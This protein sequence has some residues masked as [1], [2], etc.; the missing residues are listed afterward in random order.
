[1]ILTTHALAGAVIGKNF[2][3]PLLIILLSTVSHFAMDNLRHGEYLNQ[4]SPLRKTWWKVALDILIGLGIIFSFI[5]FANPSGEKS[6]NIFLGSFFSMFPD[7]LTFLYW[8]MGIKFLKPIIDFH[9]KI[10]RYPKFSKE[11]EWNFRN[12]INDI[13]I[14]LI[15]ICL[16]IAF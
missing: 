3:N 13:I 4:S 11:R 7:L 15:S 8:K 2:G 6:F 5:Y 10:H 12:S 16:L 9:S 1:M 14:S